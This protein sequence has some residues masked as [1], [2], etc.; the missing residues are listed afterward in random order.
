M[1][2]QKAKINII[3]FNGDSLPDIGYKNE[4]I[5]IKNMMIRKTGEN[6]FLT[7][8]P[9][10]RIFSNERITVGMWNT[11][12]FICS[13]GTSVYFDDGGSKIYSKDAIDNTAP[14]L[15]ATLS[16][17]G[18]LGASGPFSKGAKIDYSGTQNF[19]VKPSNGNDYMIRIP[20]GGTPAEFSTGLSAEVST[21]C[22]V[23]QMDNYGLIFG[24]TGKL[25][26][27][28]PIDITSWSALD[29]I[30][31]P[32]MKSFLVFKDKIFIATSDKIFAYYN[33]NS[34]PFVKVS[35]L[36]IANGV[37]SQ[38]LM[39][40]D[41]NNVFF[42]D[43]RGRLCKIVNDSFEV[44]NKKYVGEFAQMLRT[45]TTYWKMNLSYLNLFGK[46]YIL[47]SEKSKTFPQY[48]YD[49]DLNVIYE[50]DNTTHGSKYQPF[51][52]TVPLTANVSN[53]GELRVG[54]ESVSSNESSSTNVSFYYC[55]DPVTG[56]R[57]YAS[58][59]QSGADGG[60]C[61]VGGGYTVSQ[62]IQEVKFGYNDY[63]TSSRKMSK[64]LRLGTNFTSASATNPG[65]FSMYASDDPNEAYYK[66]GDF[67]IPYIN[68]YD[69]DNIFEIRALGS[70]IRRSYRLLAGANST[71]SSYNQIC[72]SEIEEELKILG[73]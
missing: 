17:G 13:F 53:P 69:K 59:T 34:T 72:I 37:H 14:T 15:E 54:I 31:I 70:Y 57:F 65:A 67:V 46:N 21:P 56:N 27:S 8:R 39:C 16:Y 66:I 55:I 33:D 51:A 22:L 36:E 20:S 5:S 68:N 50:W 24:N 12:R 26:F 28:D 48:V 10:Q 30:G 73:S 9:E 2:Y 1:P 41:G 47:F 43:P 64:M 7:T 71:A 40:T 61:A 49:I 62:Y 58:D 23:D 11:P 18:G 19:I 45:I 4:P 63:G 35:G 44:V 29:F 38:N 60:F 52:M 25:F 6:F 42:I 32:D 3:P